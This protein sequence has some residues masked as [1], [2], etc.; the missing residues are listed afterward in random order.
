ME[1]LDNLRSAVLQQ[2]EEEVTHSAVPRQAGGICL[3][4]AVYGWQRQELL[5]CDEFNP[6]GMRWMRKMSCFS[7]F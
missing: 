7:S 1:L 3:D 2:R 6:K 5:E 4:G